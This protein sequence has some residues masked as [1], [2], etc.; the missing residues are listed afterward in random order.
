[1]NDTNISGM[2]VFAVVLSFFS[3]VTTS[4]PRSH[5]H[6]WKCHFVLYSLCVCAWYKV[7]GGVLVRA[8]SDAH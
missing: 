1:M 6:M 4:K 7:G 2:G 8:E 5:S 3:S